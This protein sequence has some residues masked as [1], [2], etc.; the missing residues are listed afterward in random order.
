M[1]GVEKYI[2]DK[3]LVGLV[4]MVFALVILGWQLKKKQ[5]GDSYQWIWI[6]KSG[7]VFYDD[8]SCE[9]IPTWSETPSDGI[10]YEL[11]SKPELRKYLDELRK[12][13]LSE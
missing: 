7:E 13:V 8:G 11:E 3:F 12:K 9:E 5:D 2:R 4:E 6:S 1:D 10:D